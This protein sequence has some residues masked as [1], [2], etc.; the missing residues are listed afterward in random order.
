MGIFV[1]NT[2]IGIFGG[3]FDPI[4]NGH[5]RMAVELLE[6]LQ[7]QQLRLLPCYQPV[8]RDM[9]GASAEQRLH[10]LQLAIQDCPETM[11]IDT[12]EITRQGP[13][14]MYDTLKSIRQE[15]PNVPLALIMGSD[16]FLG[17][18]RW[19]RWQALLQLC[20]IIVMH[21]PGWQLQQQLPELKQYVAQH[22]TEQL[23]DLQQ[24]PCGCLYFTAVTQLEISATEIRKR[25]QQA[26]NCQFLLPQQVIDYLIKQ[27]IYHKKS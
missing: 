13:S 9:P 26:Q 3:T 25:L 20:H 8:H 15:Q 19:Y 21:R 11:C 7:L 22:Q 23:A 17:L 2:M 4:H 12:R 24:Q 10:M 16:A 27:R 18:P 6:T 1:N 5:L 14:Y